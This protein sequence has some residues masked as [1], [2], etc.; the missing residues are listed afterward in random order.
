M[1]AIHQRKDNAY[2]GELEKPL[3][4]EIEGIADAAD[5]RGK[6]FRCIQE[7]D[8]AKTYGPTGSVKEYSKDGEIGPAGRSFI[9]QE[10]VIE[11]QVYMG[12]QLE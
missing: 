6:D 1:E 9:G 2:H 4:Q 11:H 5:P 12:D 7:L 10:D 8:R 3:H